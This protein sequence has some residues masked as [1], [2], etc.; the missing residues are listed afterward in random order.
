L[1]TYPESRDLDI[2][3]SEEEE[4]TRV[5][6]ACVST[7]PRR[8]DEDAVP[9]SITQIIEADNGKGRVDWAE[10]WRYRELM[11]FL[12]WRD[13]KVRYKQT[14]LGA[15]WAILQPFL[16]MIVFS[17]FFGRLA[18]LDQKTGGIPYPVYVYAGLLPWTFF[19]NALVASNN[20]LVGSANLITKVYFPRLIIPI[21]AVGAGLV[22]LGI[23]F[24]VLLGMMLYY[25]TPVT[26]NLLL[27][28]LLL[29]GT[30]LAATGMGTLLAG[31]TVAYRDF[32]H[33]VPFLT[34]LWMFA[35]P[36]IYP[37]SIVPE[38]WRPL[39]ALNPMAGIID[40]YRAA[41]L[42]RPVHWPELGI[43]LLAALL[44]FHIGVTHFSRVEHRFADVI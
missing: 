38:M 29:A 18:G 25:G 32:R 4:G 23:S 43:S 15:A 2:T 20:S 7:P 6:E 22:D 31:L 3:R 40:G 37:P 36:V 24:L 28:P 9:C 39:L 41:F 26:W 35:T 42:G 34:Q 16:T 19:A 13:V 33:V 5:S 10:L 21:A 11:G 14:A 30:L 27:V 8:H 17:I 12:G 44:L 1:R